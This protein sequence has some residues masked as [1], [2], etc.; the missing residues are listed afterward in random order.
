MPILKDRCSKMPLFIKPLTRYVTLRVAHA[1]GM[2]GTSS[3]PPTSNETASQRSRHASWHV[4]WCMSGWLTRGDGENVPGIPGACTTRNFTYLARGPWS[5]IRIKEI[6]WPKTRDML[7]FKM[8]AGSHITFH[9]WL[10]VPY[11][12]VTGCVKP[13][14]KYILVQCNIAA[15]PSLTHCGYPKATQSHQH[16]VVSICV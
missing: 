12:I 7:I 2:P 14:M 9:G 4:S 3:S 6:F 16:M 11:L 5:F 15:S 8:T 13:S 10:I 1:P